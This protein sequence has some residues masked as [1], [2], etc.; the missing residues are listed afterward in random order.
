MR[1]GKLPLA[2]VA[3]IAWAAPEVALAF[4]EKPAELEELLVAVRRVLEGDGNG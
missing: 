3:L 4:F 1:L 2:L